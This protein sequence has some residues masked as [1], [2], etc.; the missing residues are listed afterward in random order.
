[1]MITKKCSCIEGKL[2]PMIPIPGKTIDDYPDCPDCDGSGFVEVDGM[3]IKQGDLYKQ[4]RL[5]RHLTL[6]AFCKKYEVD[7]VKVSRVERGLE[8]ANK[9]VNRDIKVAYMSMVTTEA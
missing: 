7:P 8:P 6:R 9:E 1:M 5:D 4:Q 3:W 2:L